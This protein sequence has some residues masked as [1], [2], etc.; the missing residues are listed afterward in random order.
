[1]QRHNRHQSYKKLSPPTHNDVVHLEPTSE[2][3][4]TSSSFTPLSQGPLETLNTHRIIAQSILRCLPPSFPSAPFVLASFPLPF[5]SCARAR[6]PE[7]LFSSTTRPQR[8][9]TVRPNYC[10]VAQEG[11]RWF[12]SFAAVGRRLPVLVVVAHHSPDYAAASVIEM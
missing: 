3:Q 11:H 1:M 2:Q 6:Q 7:I 4:P 10:L 9:C 8:N 12:N 5:P